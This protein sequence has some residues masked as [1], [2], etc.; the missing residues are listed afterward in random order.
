MVTKSQIS[1]FDAPK[2]SII[3]HA[4]NSQG[5]WG[6]GIAK[7]FNERYPESYKEYQMFC[8]ELNY[9]RKTACGRGRLSFAH[10][11][12]PHWVGWIVT[13]HNYGSLKDNRENIKINTTLALVDICEAIY[14]AHPKDTWPQVDVYSNKFNSGLFD[15]PWNESELILTTV[16]RDFKR[17]NWIVC[18]PEESGEQE[19]TKGISPK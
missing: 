8:K 7:E 11:S 5:M 6:S 19:D 18:S 10:V 2:D 4:C 9:S 15:V 3:I 13:S 17:I 16:L 12:E 14:K 1:L